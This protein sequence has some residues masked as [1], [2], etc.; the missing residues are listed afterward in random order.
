MQST[1]FIITKNNK[2]TLK[3]ILNKDNKKETKFQK[4][5]NFDAIEIPTQSNV[6]QKGVNCPIQKGT[7]LPVQNDLKNLNLNKAPKEEKKEEKKVNKEFMEKINSNILNELES[8]NFGEPTKY[9]KPEDFGT[10][11]YCKNSVSL[12]SNIYPIEI[13]KDYTIYSYRVEFIE[14][15]EN[16]NTFLKKKIVSKSFMQLKPLYKTYF[17]SAEAFYSTEKIDEIK[18]FE[19]NFN[20]TKHYFQIK[21]LDESFKIS[22]NPKDFITPENRFILKNIFELIFKD[23]LKG[24]P[25]LKME[26]NLFIRDLEVNPINN[27]FD[28][29]QLVLKPG[30]STKI[31]ILENGIFLNVDNKCKI[32]NSK[33]CFEMMKERTKGKLNANSMKSLENYF[34]GRLIELKHT[35]Q[36]MKI[37]G[38]SFDKTIK[39]TNLNYGGNFF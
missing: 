10:P 32:I 12:Y 4:F 1:N 8:E 31:L 19:M 39:N 17:F 5:N 30:Y 27:R 36:K 6:I 33:D 37:E 14:A 16:M 34:K 24:N 15:S 38:I 25:D 11:D 23:I 13:I 26:K 18:H 20:S 29:K 28:N 35:G 3:D 9:I 7:N 2:A 21:P 22:K